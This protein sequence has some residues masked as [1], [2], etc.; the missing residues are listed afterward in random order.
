[1]AA[2]FITTGIYCFVNSKVAKYLAMSAMALSI[3][4]GICDFFNYSDEIANKLIWAIVALIA[5][6]ANNNE[7]KK[8]KSEKVF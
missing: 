1:M 5:F 2:L 3:L 4:I 8:A 7:L 6:I